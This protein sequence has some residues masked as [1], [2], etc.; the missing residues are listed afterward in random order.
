MLDLFITKHANR[1]IWLIGFP[2]LATTFQ[3]HLFGSSISLALYFEYVSYKYLLNTICK[4][5]FPLCMS[6]ENYK[7]FTYMHWL[8][9]FF[10]LSIGLIESVCHFPLLLFFLIYGLYAL[11]SYVLKENHCVSNYLK[12]SSLIKNSSY[13]S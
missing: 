7:Y 11:V 1:C 10:L 6:L 8:Y 4:S 2:G 3:V 12:H 9:C 13:M 5:V